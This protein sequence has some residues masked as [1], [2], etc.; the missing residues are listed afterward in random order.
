MVFITGEKN[1]PNK[2]QTVCLSSPHEDKLKLNSFQSGWDHILSCGKVVSGSD[3]QNRAKMKGTQLRIQ[4]R[5][6][7]KG[8]WSSSKL[9]KLLNC[10]SS[11]H[12]TLFPNIQRCSF[13]YIFK[14]L[15]KYLYLNNLFVL[16]V[17]LW[18]DGDQQHYFLVQVKFWV[19]DF[20]VT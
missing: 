10:H 16:F 14:Y 11:Y 17:C 18:R 7:A 4:A 19:K 13:K 8:E 15:F 2:K 20:S 1:Q 5:N 12:P 3:L 9:F 6:G